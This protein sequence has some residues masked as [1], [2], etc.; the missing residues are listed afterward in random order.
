MSESDGKPG[1]TLGDIA[2]R[3]DRPVWMVRRLYERGS[4]EEPA[5]V[6]GYRVVPPADLP[7]VEAAMRRAGY[8]P[9]EA[10]ETA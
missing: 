5:R 7:L 6:G 2:R 10:P 8:L 3:Y 4:L 1:W 9:A